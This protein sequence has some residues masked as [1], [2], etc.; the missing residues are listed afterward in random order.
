MNSQNLQTGIFSKSKLGILNRS[1]WYTHCWFKNKR[2]NIEYTTE[3]IIIKRYNFGSRQYVFIFKQFLRM[4]I[5]VI[6]L[7]LLFL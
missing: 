4:N 5:T 6:T 1:T 3:C 2:Y 7:H